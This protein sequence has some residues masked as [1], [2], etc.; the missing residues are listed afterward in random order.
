MQRRPADFLQLGITSVELALLPILTP[1][2]T[3]AD[4]IHVSQLMVL[5]AIAL[6]RRPPRRRTDR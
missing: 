2:F 1:T 5:L 3:L 4:W 6:T